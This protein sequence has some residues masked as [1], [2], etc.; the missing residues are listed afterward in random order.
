MYSVT[1]SGLSGAGVAVTVNAACPPSTMSDP[2]VTLT[3]GLGSSSSSTV[4]P[5]PAGVPST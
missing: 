4:T 2:A 3:S 5:A 1:R